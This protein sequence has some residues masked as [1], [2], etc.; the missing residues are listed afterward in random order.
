MNTSLQE[1]LAKYGVMRAKAKEKSNG[2]YFGLSEQGQN[3]YSM[4]Y[5]DKLSDLGL[6]GGNMLS[7]IAPDDSAFD[8]LAP[9]ELG[10][11]VPLSNPTKVRQFLSK[12]VDSV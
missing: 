7:I 8:L 6:D 11:K 2:K 12:L 3:N 1:E 5:S 10:E 9:K 4:D